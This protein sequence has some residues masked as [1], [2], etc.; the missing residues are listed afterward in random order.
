MRED[1]HWDLW[2]PAADLMAEMINRLQLYPGPT[3]DIL[4]EL[5]KRVDAHYQEKK[6]GLGMR[7]GWQELTEVRYTILVKKLQGDCTK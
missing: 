2:D 6:L 4:E 3:Y 1:F 7:R 5:K